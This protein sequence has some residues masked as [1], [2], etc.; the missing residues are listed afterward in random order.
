MNPP[1]IS[2]LMIIVLAVIGLSLVAQYTIQLPDTTGNIPITGQ[3]LGVLL[4]TYLMGLRDGSIALLLYLFCGMIG[5]PV[6]A[7]GGSGFDAFTGPSGGFLYGFLLTCVLTN[8]IF[9]HRLSD[10][11]SLFQ[12]MILGTVLILVFGGLHLRLFMDWEQ[13]WTHGIEPFLPGA[14]IKLLIAWIV[15]Y[16]LR[17]YVLPTKQSGLDSSATLTGNSSTRAQ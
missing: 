17:H 6:F 8:L 14:C 7:D 12:F 9:D 1:L 13:V 5:L 15:A 3:S 11:R 4:I 2:R 10:Y 16:G